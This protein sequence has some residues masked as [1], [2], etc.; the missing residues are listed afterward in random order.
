[1]QAFISYAFK[2]ED[3]FENLA[4][5]LDG[6]QIPRWKTDE[7]VAG[8]PLR[9]RLRLAVT[10]CPVCIFLATRNSL[11]SSWC[12]AEVGAFWGAGKPVI[13]YVDDT[14]LEE[15]Q[16]PKQLQGDKWTRQ[17]KEV[18]AAVKVHTDKAVECER[19]RR[20]ALVEYNRDSMALYANKSQA[21]REATSAVW[22]IGA[23]LHHC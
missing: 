22:L 10:K 9:E 21:L 1:M 18:V 6:H 20:S 15:E 4:F 3:K 12:L 19:A 16:L 5:V 8:E 23:T 7:I 13:V 17:V 2:D 14:D 11:E